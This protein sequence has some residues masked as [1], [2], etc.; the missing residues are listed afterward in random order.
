MHEGKVA[1]INLATKTHSCTFTFHL[2]VSMSRGCPRVSQLQTESS[3]EPLTF[4]KL[5]HQALVRGNPTAVSGG[6]PELDGRVTNY[7]ALRATVVLY[8][9]QHA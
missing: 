5:L 4:Y 6:F 2:I 1:Q 8:Y 9:R 3:V 7:N